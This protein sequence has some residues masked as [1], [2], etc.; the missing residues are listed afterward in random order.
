MANLFLK[1]YA[2]THAL[3]KPNY[4]EPQTASGIVYDF[5]TA[6]SKRK[7]KRILQKRTVRDKKGLIILRKHP[8]HFPLEE[9]LK[10]ELS[11]HIN[12]WLQHDG[13]SPYNYKVIDAIFRVAGTGSLGLN[14]YVLLLKSINNVGE[15]YLLIDMKQ[16]TQSSLQPYIKIQQPEWSTQAERINSV[17]HIMQNR[18]PALLS[19]TVFRD[20][21]YLI[22]EMQPV[23][24]SINFKLICNHYR[25]MCQVITDMGMLTASAHLR[26]TGRLR[27]VGADDLITYGKDNQWHEAVLEYA[28]EYSATLKQYYSQ[29]KETYKNKF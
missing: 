29:Y 3:G 13:N 28:I 20:Q 23:K 7:R 12:N 21:S 22:E 11:N 14:R 17:Q 4:I 2:K 25:S 1:S 16:A 24:D 27:A 26:G 5:L 18:A 10:V 9:K 15:K 19:T 6:V 8:K